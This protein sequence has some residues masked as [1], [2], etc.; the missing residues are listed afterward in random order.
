MHEHARKWRHHDIIEDNLCPPHLHLILLT[1]HL[2]IKISKARRKVRS[3]ERKHYDRTKRRIHC[4][5]NMLIF[6]LSLGECVCTLYKIMMHDSPPIL[7]V[8][9][10]THLLPGEAWTCLKKKHKSLLLL[11]LSPLSLCLSL[12]F[13]HTIN[14]KTLLD[15]E[16]P[17]SPVLLTT[18]GCTFTNNLS[19]GRKG[20]KY[21][22]PVV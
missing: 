10:E 19:L 15:W 12:T 17:I 7:C 2:L 9:I 1:P 14:S 8:V 11:S 22:Q 20:M 13:S 18:V 16:N 5:L 4:C 21:Q 3:G 6:V